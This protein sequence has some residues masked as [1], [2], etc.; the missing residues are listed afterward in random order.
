[1]VGL[2]NERMPLRSRLL[3]VPE[4][5]ERYIE[6]LRF[7]AQEQLAPEKFAAR[8][9]HYRQLIQPIVE[10]DTRKLSTTEAF[11]NATATNDSSS[12]ENSLLQFAAKRSK[13]LR[14]Y[15][16]RATNESQR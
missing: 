12:G 3:Q 16:V 7:I 5:R 15:N 1:L 8:V 13:F 6:H 4:L 2:D 11:V 14:E 10:Q 9:E